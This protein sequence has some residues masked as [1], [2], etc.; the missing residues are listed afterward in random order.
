MREPF[1]PRTCP[2]CGMPS[3]V[4]H[5]SEAG[6]IEALQAEIE[7]TR[8]RLQQ[9]SGRDGPAPAPSKDAQST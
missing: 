2:F 9:G 5:E 8:Q 4:P 7:L 6:C 3:S 1:P